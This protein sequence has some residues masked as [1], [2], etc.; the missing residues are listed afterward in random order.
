MSTN[1][2]PDAHLLGLPRELREIIYD[3][4][5]EDPTLLWQKNTPLHVTANS[6]PPV[7]LLLAHS[8]LYAETIPHFYRHTTITVYLDAFDAIKSQDGDTTFRDALVACP[9]I[10][11]TRTIELCPRMNAGVEFLVAE[12]DVA[13]TVLLQEAKA[14]RTLIVGWSEVPRGFIPT[15]RPWAYKAIALD[16]LKRFI[17]KVDIV[18]GEVKDPPPRNGDSDQKGLERAVAMILADGENLKA[19]AC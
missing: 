18:A 4:L 19:V 5:A 13:V 16:S 3:F 14:L 6:P 2:Y 15:W 12:M 11:Q 1:P 7:E 10:K 17:G 9:H 8:L